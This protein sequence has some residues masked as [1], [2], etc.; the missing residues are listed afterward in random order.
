MG[1]PNAEFF[2]LEI[3]GWYSERIDQDARGLIYI[4][5]GRLITLANHTKTIMV[6]DFSNIEWIKKFLYKYIRINFRRKKW[7]H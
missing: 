4:L 6:L 7:P 3:D 5:T 1:S 2:D